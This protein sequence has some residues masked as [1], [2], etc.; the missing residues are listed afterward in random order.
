[1]ET[2]GADIYVGPSTGTVYL[3]PFLPAYAA[4]L[5]SQEKKLRRTPISTTGIDLSRAVILVIGD[6][7]QSGETVFDE[8]HYCA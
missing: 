3:E 8:R 2:S 7:S 5:N 1:V 4:T 6:K